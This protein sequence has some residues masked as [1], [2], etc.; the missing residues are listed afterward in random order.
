[1][2]VPIDQVCDIFAG[3]P[4]AAKASGVGGVAVSVIGIRSVSVDGRIDLSTP[5][6]LHVPSLP[7]MRK[8]IVAGDVLL[9]LRGTPKAGLVAETGMQPI[10]ASSNLAILRPKAQIDPVFLWAA[11]QREC[12]EEGELAHF[13]AG[14]AQRSLRVKDIALLQITLPSQNAQKAIGNAV[15]SI[16]TAIDAQRAAT[17]AAEEMLDSFLAESL[18]S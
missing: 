3:L 14:T 9:A 15:R 16:Q 17:I 1:M 12:R 5:E 10:Y 6:T 8:A 13:A 2:P 4:A 11:V 18:S 7:E